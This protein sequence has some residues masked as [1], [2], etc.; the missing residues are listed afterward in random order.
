MIFEWIPYPEQTPTKADANDGRFLVMNDKGIDIN[1]FDFEADG[2]T[3][4]NWIYNH[5]PVTHWACL[6]KLPIKQ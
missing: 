1:T 6:P 5:S 2:Y 4:P 3:T